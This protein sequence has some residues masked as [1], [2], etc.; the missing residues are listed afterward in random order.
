[1]NRPTG[2]TAPGRRGP[3]PSSR[4]RSCPAPP[5]AGPG[6][7]CAPRPPRAAPGRRARRCRGRSGFR[8]PA[9]HR[10]VRRHARRRPFPPRE[11]WRAPRAPRRHGDGPSPVPARSPR[12][13]RPSGPGH[14]PCR[15]AH[16]RRR[17]SRDRSWQ[18]RRDP[19]ADSDPGRPCGGRP[20]A[21]GSAAACGRWSPSPR[22]AWLR[23]GG[24]GYSMGNS[25][26]HG[27]AQVHVDSGARAVVAVPNRG[28][29]PAVLRPPGR[30]GR[31]RRGPRAGGSAGARS[32]RRAVVARTR[33]GAPA[34]PGRP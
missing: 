9:R 24:R 13:G 34:S 14:R 27:N 10:R 32:R 15:P 17:R 20:C 33:P 16:A 28:D 3:R 30:P 4:P 12:C 21:A 25:P 6:A 5:G 7:A 22:G 19:C 2:G 11:R 8:R 1:M 26:L 18:A 23:T 29:Q 31:R